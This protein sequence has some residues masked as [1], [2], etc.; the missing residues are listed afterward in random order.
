MVTDFII[1][2]AKFV[3]FVLSFGSD[4]A[5]ADGAAAAGKSGLR[6]LL[7]G[8]KNALS[9]GFKTLKNIATSGAVR[10]VFMNKVKT[11]ALNKLKAFAI[12]QIEEKAIGEI[13]GKIGDK[14][15]DDAKTKSQPTSFNVES[16]D[17]LHISDTKKDCE[18]ITD[19]NS[20]VQCAKD[21]IEAIAVIDPTG[22]ASMA[23]A[24][25]QPVCDV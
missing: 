8:A 9:D 17:P 3:G 21:I 10:G 4:S 6:T 25:M 12:T 14:I 24:F 23:G 22:L 18:N 19:E 11:T 7:N 1:G 5:V 16:L 13:C 15:L 2:L 20:K